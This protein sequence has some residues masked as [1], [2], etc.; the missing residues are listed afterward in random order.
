MITGPTPP[1]H[2]HRTERQVSSGGDH[3]LREPWAFELTHMHTKNQAE[4]KGRDH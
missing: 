2:R 4:P 3:S 1:G